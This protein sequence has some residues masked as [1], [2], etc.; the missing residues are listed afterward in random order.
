MNMNIKLQ[1]F[2]TWSGLVAM[3]LFFI[4]LLVATFFPPIAPSL[5]GDQIAA[6]YQANQGRIL[7]GS[8]IIIISSAFAGPFAA[9]VYCQ[10]SRMEGQR[11]VCSMGQF[12]AGI[13]N[14]AF[15]ILPG[16]FWAAM[17]FR[18]DRNVDALYAM[19]D[20]AWLVTMF[21]WTVGAMQVACVALAVL[22]HGTA[23][24]VYPRWVGFFCAWIT[25]GMATSS[26]IIFFKTGPFA[27]NGLVGFWIPAT[28]FGLWFGVMWWMTLKAVNQEAA[29]ETAVPSGAAAT[30]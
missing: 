5:A 4:G 22:V 14:I 8:L 21:P 17:A 26:V 15:F 12:A 10:L 1:R 28:V 23:T 16:V 30:A 20:I 6:H 18:P 13:A 3:I 27:W 7:A 25:V 29:E 24:S 9:A 2:C 11:P 19:H